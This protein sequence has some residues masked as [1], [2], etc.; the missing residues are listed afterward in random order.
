MTKHDKSARPSRE[1]KALLGKMR[2][3]KSLDG[4]L[5][6]FAA[7]PEELG[8]SAAAAAKRERHKR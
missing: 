7:T 8:K 5:S 1:F 6:L 3:K 2:T 4:A